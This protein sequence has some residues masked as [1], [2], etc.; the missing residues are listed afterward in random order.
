MRRLSSGR[1][2]SEET[3]KKLSL[4]LIGNKRGIGN[5]NKRGTHLSLKQKT[6]LSRFYGITEEIE[7]KVITLYKTE[8][9]IAYR[10]IARQCSI[11]H[12]TVKLILVRSGLL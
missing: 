10:E 5:T 6:K 2:H 3:K 9:K 1:T 11:T 12:K 7:N 4:L 8:N